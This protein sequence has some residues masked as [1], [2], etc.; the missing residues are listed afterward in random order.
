ML[1]AEKRRVMTL[2][3]AAKATW[4]FWPKS[5]RLNHACLSNK[6]E[7]Q[8]S[9][10]QSPRTFWPVAGIE[11]SGW[12]RFSEYAQSSRFVFSTNQI[13]KIWREVRELRTSGVRPSQSSRSLPQA[14]GRIV[15]PGNENGGSMESLVFYFS[16]FSL[17]FKTNQNRACKGTRGKLFVS[18]SLRSEKRRSEGRDCMLKRTETHV[19]VHNNYGIS[20]LKPH[21]F[22][23]AFIPIRTLLELHTLFPKFE[24]PSWSHGLSVQG[25]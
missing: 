22:V 18:S 20:V 2:I 9:R 15:S 12:T 13:C 23:L 5:Y 8:H 24:L 1:L 17:F 11:S 7:A 3:T 21:L 16:S 6:V 19:K 25:V 4:M 14:R 10:P